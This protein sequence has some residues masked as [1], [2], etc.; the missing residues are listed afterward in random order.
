MRGCAMG[1]VMVSLQPARA[2][3]VIEASEHVGK[4]AEVFRD[5]RAS[6]GTCAGVILGDGADQ[7]SPIVEIVQATPDLPPGDYTATFWLTAAPI[8]IMHELSVT[9]TA[10]DTQVTLRQFQFDHEQQYRPYEIAFLHTGGRARLRLQAVSATGFAGMRVALSKDEHSSLPQLDNLIQDKLDAGPRP[11]ALSVEQAIDLLEGRRDVETI[12]VFDHRVLCDRIEIRARRQSRVLVRNIEVDK[13]HYK[14]RETVQV[15][16]AI[17]AI[18]APGSLVLVAEEIREIDD[19][20]EV[21]RKTLD[22]AVGAHEMQFAYTLDDAEFGRELRCSLVRDGQVYHANSVFFGVSRNVYRVGITGSGGPQDMRTMTRKGADAIMAANKA[23]YANYFERFAWAPCDYSNLAPADEIFFSG[24][25]QYPGSISGYKYLLAAAHAV[26]IKGI[27]YGKACAGGIEGF[28]TFQRH[29]EFFGHSPEGPGTEAFNTFYLERMLANDYM[30]HAP[31]SEGGWQHWASVWTRFDYDPAVAFGARAVMD[32]IEMFGWDG[33]RWDGHFVGNMRPF[34]DTLLAAYPDFLH[35]YNIAFANPDATRF[36]P[37]AFSSVE[38]F[39]LVASNHGLMMDESVRDWSH[40]SFSPGHIR[41]FYDA[42]TREADYIKRIGGLP[43]FITF[44]MASNQDLTWNVIFG[45]AAGQRYT[46]INSPGDFLYGPLPRFLTR[47]SALIWDDTARLANPDDAIIIKPADL[48]TT[49]EALWWRESTWLRDLG[50]GRYQLLVNL[51]NP[52]RYRQFSSRVQTPAGQRENVDIALTLPAGARL[53]RAVHASPDLSGG[54][55]ILPVAVQG[56]QRTVV[57]PRLH[58]WS[59]VVFDI[60]GGPEPP[61]ALTTPVEDAAA[62]LE[63]QSEERARKEAERRAEAGIGPGQPDTP[64]ALPPY[65]DY[66]RAFNADA[67][68]AKALKLPDT[69]SIRRNGRLDVH[70]ARGVFAWLN[71][72]EAAAAQIETSGTYSPSWVDYVGFRR[73][74]QG[75]MDDYPETLEDLTMFDVVVL[76]NIHAVHLGPRRRALLNEYVKAGGSLMVMGGYFNLSLGADHNTALA[77]ALPVRIRRY[78]DVH[79]D[80]RGLRLRPVAESFFDKGIVWDPPAHAYMVDTSPLTD[81]ATVLLCADEH[82]AIVARRYGQGRIITVMINPHGAPGDGTTPYWEWHHWPRVL[83]SCLRWLGEDAGRIVKDER[84]RRAIDPSKPT[85]EDLMLEACILSDAEFT[86]RLKAAQENIV[87]PESARLILQVAVEQ[88]DKISDMEL[89]TDVVARASRYFDETFSGLGRSLMDSSHDF[90]REA[91]FQIAGLA[92]ERALR[93]RIQAALGESN[94]TLVR[95]ALIA[96]GRLGDPAAAPVVRRYLRS[97]PSEA[98][99]ANSVLLQL[100]DTGLLDDALQA[101][102]EGVRRSLRLKSGR[103]SAHENLHGGTSFKLTPEARRSAMVEYRRVI[104]LEQ[105]ALHDMRHFR[106]SLILLDQ[107]HWDTIA[108]FFAGTETLELQ[109]GAF[110]FMARIP[111]E[112]VSKYRERFRSARLPG[113][114]LLAE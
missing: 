103:R 9:L 48:E 10:N 88:V 62:I 66:E 25:T 35:G 80:N 87:D 54:H 31:P 13:I 78:D 47:Y 40:S 41:P 81:D 17:L 61:F 93:P 95:E 92:G 109:A 94:P 74:A 90:I 86:A 27:T 60:E 83:Q 12:G 20:R 77:Q 5:N 79:R 29:P 114:R 67:E 16:L 106:E 58:R 63:Q 69:V 75:C 45:L 28:L 99:L 53:L 71:P 56:E 96:L 51:V 3:V 97:R 113:L 64:Q 2:L 26:G 52:P 22:P 15:H 98:F 19:V 59:I 70:H 57:L 108:A 82:P 84:D 7:R 100:G 105:Q 68:I 49:E 37:S 76:D 1:L 91:G 43:L 89:L 73:G 112:E 11:D 33:I 14:P 34:L 44:D 42:I 104:Q 46:Y 110:A 23:R 111:P 50:N 65:R 6:N 24:Q 8:A 21:F 32:G 72:I 102:E 85:A 107:V 4:Q 55:E 30:L 38:D 39:H 18:E 36:L 101:Y